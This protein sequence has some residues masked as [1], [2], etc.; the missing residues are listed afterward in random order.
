MSAKVSTLRIR[1]HAAGGATAAARRWEPGAPDAEHVR[2]IRS[3]WERV[4]P[5]TSGAYVNLQTADE[6]VERADGGNDGRLLE[7]KRAYD[8]VGLFRSIRS[9]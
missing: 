6:S 5:F 1:L 8:P 3:A 4:A 2:W 7:L 9:S